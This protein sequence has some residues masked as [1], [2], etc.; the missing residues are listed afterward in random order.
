MGYTE[1]KEDDLIKLAELRLSNVGKRYNITKTSIVNKGFNE[2]TQ[3][4][5]VTFNVKSI[6][7][8][9]LTINF[10]TFYPNEFLFLQ[11]IGVEFK[12]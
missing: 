3:Q 7:D 9:P 6:S 2:I 5:F 10:T 12:N 8:Y 1:I 11:K 4:F